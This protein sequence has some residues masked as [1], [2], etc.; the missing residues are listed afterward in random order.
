MAR[1]NRRVPFSPIRT[2]HLAI[3]PLAVGDAAAF[4]AYRD[5]P[6]TARYQDWDL[7]Y[8][9]DDALRLIHGLDADGWPVP[10]EWIQLAVVLDGRLIGDVA[11]GLSADGVTADIGY[12]LAP[13]VRGQGFATEAVDAVLDRLRATGI[14]TFRASVDPANA[15]SIRLL[16]RLG[17]VHVGRTERSALVRGEW[18]DD[19]HYELAGD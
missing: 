17:F 8:T 4:A 3:R 15:G 12:T 16:E 7:P 6:G 2:P 11:V 5:D 14:R 1:L 19:D 9:I 18:V 10:G 13:D